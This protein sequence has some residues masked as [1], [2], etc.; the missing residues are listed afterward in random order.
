MSTSSPNG[1]AAPS[2]ESLGAVQEIFLRPV[3]M[4]R[5]QWLVEHMVQLVLDHMR[6]H[7]CDGF[8]A[9]WADEQI[10]AAVGFKLLSVKKLK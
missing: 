3:D 8:Q 2:P 6:E 1:N 9:Q 4:P 5:A 7:K 10:E